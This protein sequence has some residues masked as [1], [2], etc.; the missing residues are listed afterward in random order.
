MNIRPPS[1][2]VPCKNMHVQYL[3]DRMRPDEIENYLALTG[4]ASYDADVC[5]RGLMNVPGPK[6]TLLG[7]D[8]LPIVCGGFEEIR[9]GV[10]SMWMIGTLDGWGKHWRSIT[11]AARWLS[12]EVLKTSRRIEVSSI[13][14]R[15]C[16]IDWYVRALG[17]VCEGVRRKLGA[18]GE[19]VGIYARVNP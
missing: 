11:K 8:G 2:I 13:T 1:G 9:P 16:A 17:F 10:C 15:V 12:E 14:S 3:C 6:M 7:E 4:A 5:A 18:N 19:D